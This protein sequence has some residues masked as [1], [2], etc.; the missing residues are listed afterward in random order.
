MDDQGVLALARTSLE[1]TVEWIDTDAAG[2]QHNS[3]ILR[4]VEAAEAE[5]F[6]RL[7]V[8]EYF[9]VAPRVHQSTNFKAKLRFGQR[10][11][12]EV[13]IVA[14]GRTSMTFTFL[15]T[16]HAFEGHAA[17]TAAH[18][19]FTTVHVPVG[20]VRPAGWPPNIRQAIT[21]PRQDETAEPIASFARRTP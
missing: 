9:P 8:P 6:R 19:T 20:Q 18:G 7:G 12:V 13:A 14:I 1:R 2:H 21:A 17:G 16:G 3:A 10:I 15:V 11:T 5:L 4:W